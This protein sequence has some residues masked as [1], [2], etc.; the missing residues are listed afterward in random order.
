MYSITEC[1]INMSYVFKKDEF[2]ALLASNRRSL[3]ET[4]YRYWNWQR[5]QMKKNLPKNID[6]FVRMNCVYSMAS[7]DVHDPLN[8]CLL[9]DVHILSK[10]QTNV[11]K[12]VNLDWILEN[13]LPYLSSIF[14]PESKRVN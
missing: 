1:W 8:D 12:E 3:I 5:V 14:F 10:E 13:S 2:N 9:F 4:Y 7:R 6:R 11:Y